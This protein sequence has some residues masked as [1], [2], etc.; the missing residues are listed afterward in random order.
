MRASMSFLGVVVAS[1]VAIVCLGWLGVLGAPLLV[2]VGGF[3]LLTAR[4]A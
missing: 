3:A 2:G 1:A 4:P